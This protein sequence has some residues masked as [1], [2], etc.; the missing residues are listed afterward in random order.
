MSEQN[1]TQLTPS[2]YTVRRDDNDLRVV[3]CPVCKKP[4]IIHFHARIPYT[5][6]GWPM[7]LFQCASCQ[8]YFTFEPEDGVSQITKEVAEQ[9]IANGDVDLQPNGKDQHGHCHYVALGTTKPPT[10]SNEAFD[11]A[12]GF[13]AIGDADS[14]FAALKS[15]L[16]GIYTFR[17]MTDYFK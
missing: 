5:F 1:A 17:A 10:M 8:E 2:Y 13:D 9:G 15:K 14:S 7:P 11:H 3:Q 16:P 4:E 12:M 6:N